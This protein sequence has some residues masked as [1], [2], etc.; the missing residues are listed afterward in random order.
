[1]SSGDVWVC[2]WTGCLR[3]GRCSVVT[4]AWTGWRS[5]KMER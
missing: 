5:L 2:C 4:H 3:G 1:M